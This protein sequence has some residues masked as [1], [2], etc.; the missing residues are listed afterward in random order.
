MFTLPKCKSLT[1]GLNAPL[2]LHEVD[3]RSPEQIANLSQRI[4]ES[5]I[6]PIDFLIYAP[7]YG[8]LKTPLIGQSVEDYSDAH[9]ISIFGLV[10]VIK[11]VLRLLAEQCSI[12]TFTAEGARR[13]IAQYGVMGPCKA[14]LEA[15][16]RQ[17]A[18]ELAPMRINT[19]SASPIRTFSASMGIPNFKSLMEKAAAVAPLKRNA[20]AEEVAATAVFLLSDRASAITGAMIPVDCGLHAVAG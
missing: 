10:R 18:I 7:V 11:A 14:E 3:V 5:G 9:S 19:I 16:V 15:S 17:L 4:V 8:N 6:V 2:G 12:V 13:A 1:D 20:T